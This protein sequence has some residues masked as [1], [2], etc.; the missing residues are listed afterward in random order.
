MQTSNFRV[1]YIDG[2]PDLP[3]ADEFPI[4]Y[5][6]L[7]AVTG[8]QPKVLMEIQSDISVLRMM[9]Q[10]AERWQWIEDVDWTDTF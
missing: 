9:K 1:D 8:T 2:E 10:D 5:S 3:K 7:E 6:A 4:F